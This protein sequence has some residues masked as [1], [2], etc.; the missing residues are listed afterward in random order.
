MGTDSRRGSDS[1]TRTSLVFSI[2]GPIPIQLGESE[3][4]R[5]AKWRWNSN[6]SEPVIFSSFTMDLVF[7]EVIL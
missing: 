4:I 7:L 3:Q 6:D 5:V 1:N 2:R